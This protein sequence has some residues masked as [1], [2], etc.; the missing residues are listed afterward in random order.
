MAGIDGTADSQRRDGVA[1]VGGGRARHLGASRRAGS[2]AGDDQHVER[3]AIRRSAAALSHRPNPLRRRR[4]PAGDRGHVGAQL[5]GGPGRHLRRHT[6][7]R[8]VTGDR[9]VLAVRARRHRGP[10]VRHGRDRPGR[11]ADAPSGPDH[12]GAGRP[13]GHEQ[14]PFRLVAAHASSLYLVWRSHRV[15][16]EMAAVTGRGADGGLGGGD[17]RAVV[18]DGPAA[19]AQGIRRR[20]AGEGRPWIDARPHAAKPADHLRRIRAVVVARR[21]RGQSMRWAPC[22]DAVLRRC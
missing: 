7:D 22:I 17:A 11:R 1:A 20:R 3:A 19:R 9:R 21:V 15:S 6:R 12:G 16:P 5:L 14:I 8:P 13:C 2:G 10:A 18:S 4:H